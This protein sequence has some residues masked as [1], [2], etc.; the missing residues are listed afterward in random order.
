MTAL[1]AGTKTW[2]VGLAACAW[3]ACAACATATSA[4][5]GGQ[6][7]EPT[8]A[9]PTGAANPATSASRNETVATAAGTPR[10]ERRGVD[11]P[12]VWRSPPNGRPPGAACTTDSEHF[13]VT[14]VRASADQVYVD[15]MYESANSRRGAPAA[16][17]TVTSLLLDGCPATAPPVDGWVWRDAMGPTTLSIALADLPDGELDLTLDAFGVERAVPLRKQR[18]AISRLRL[19]DRAGYYYV[20]GDPARGIAPTVGLEDPTCPT[21]EVQR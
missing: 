16:K 9:A 10:P 1:G 14:E 5:S 12:V 21:K 2:P 3:L 18:G 6:K 8:T 11:A 20:P 7:R 13:Y 19:E 4:E 15:V 17:A